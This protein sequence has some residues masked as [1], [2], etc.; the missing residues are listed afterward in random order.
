M[1]LIGNLEREV[2]EDSIVVMC[3]KKEKLRNF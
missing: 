3:E 1:Y 2:G